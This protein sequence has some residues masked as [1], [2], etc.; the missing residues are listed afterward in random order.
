MA[1]WM[2]A[3]ACNFVKSAVC[4]EKLKALSHYTQQ[5]FW[6]VPSNAPYS[7]KRNTIAACAFTFFFGGEFYFSSFFTTRSL[8]TGNWSG[9]ICYSCCSHFLFL[10]LPRQQQQDF[11]GLFNS[12]KN[13]VQKYPP[14]HFC[15]V[16]VLIKLSTLSCKYSSW[17]WL[18]QF[19]SN[20]SSA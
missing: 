10:L 19:K 15:S 13:G 6:P 16:F 4:A 3:A 11:H 5:V 9:W 12:E 7:G 20:S 2:A 1:C 14:K 8:L 17:Y 18:Y